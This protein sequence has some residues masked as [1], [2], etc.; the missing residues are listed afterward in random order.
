MRTDDYPTPISDPEAAGLPETADDDSTAYDDVDTGRAADGPDP[1]QLPLDRDDRPLAVDRFGTTPEEAREGESLDLK[2]DRE[3]PDP[4]LRDAGARPDTV[5]SPISAKS[6][7][8]DAI[9]EEIDAVDRDTA[10]DQAPVQPNAGSP[11]SMYDT[12]IG[13]RDGTVGRLVEPDQGFGE[14][15]EKDAIAT[16]A[17]A[18]GG[19]ATAEEAALHEIPET[20]DY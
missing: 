17:G 10:L 11:V 14:D 6:F 12:G 8:P 20:S 4:A 13:G 15:T 5:P 19:G 7:D 1:A 18:A 9:G 2:L 16:D 3:T